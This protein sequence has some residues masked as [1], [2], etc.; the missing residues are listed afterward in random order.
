VPAHL[1]RPAAAL[2]LALALAAL[3]FSACG[4][5][6]GSERQAL[7][8]YVKRV[9]P[10]RLGVNKLLDTADPILESYGKHEISP[11]Q[12]ARRFN[13][14]E[15]KFA[16]YTVQIAALSPVPSDIAAEQA[17]YAHTFVFE[18]AYLS[19][20]ANAIPSRS[21]DNLPNTQHEQRAAIIAWRTR[22]Q[23]LANQLGLRLPADIQVAGRGEIAP[24]PNG[25]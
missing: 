3:S 15:R 6:K 11:D 1:L 4:S 14:L 20:L 7:A 13:A 10:I 5:S 22:L 12:A 9:E 2:N 23:L 25:T 8:D 18:D 21:F 19:A 16:D 17:A 24:S